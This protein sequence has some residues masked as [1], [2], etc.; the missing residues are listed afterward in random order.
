MKF[1]TS[2]IS[3]SLTHQ[4]YMADTSRRLLPEALVRQRHRLEIWIPKSK[5]ETAGDVA[6]SL[7]AR[8]HLFNKE[9]EK[10]RMIYW[11]ILGKTTAM[12]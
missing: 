10:R 7:P 4:A 1:F 2:A 11:I 3:S 9:T 6:G 8:S 5:V 12:R